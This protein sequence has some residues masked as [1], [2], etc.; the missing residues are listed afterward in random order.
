M[1]ESIL[2]HNLTLYLTEVF[3]HQKKKWNIHLA[4][5][6][7]LIVAPIVN[8]F[9]KGLKLISTYKDICLKKTL[10][11]SIEVLKEKGNLLIFPE[12]SDDGYFE[13]LTKF[14]DGCILF[15]EYCQKKNINAKV[16]VAYYRK[17]DNKLII[18]KYKTINELLAL[19]LSR[20]E[21]ATKLCDRC[22]ELGKLEEVD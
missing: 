7:C 13:V 6:F 3:Y 9:Y 16:F 15:F 11:E 19:N 18:D 21:L 17:K 14:N 10:N 8:L 2:I 5:L 22:N 1:L 20:T 12:D 4:R